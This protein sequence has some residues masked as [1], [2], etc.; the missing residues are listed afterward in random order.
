MGGLEERELTSEDSGSNS[1]RTPQ[2]E[3]VYWINERERVRRKKES[4]ASK[5]WSDDPVFQEVYFC[6][7]HREHDKVTKWIR[8]NWSH[9]AHPNFPLAICVARIFNYPPTLTSFGFPDVWDPEALRGVLLTREWKGMQTWSGAYLITT[10][11]RKMSKVEYCVEILNAAHAADL[12]VPLSMCETL[13]G[14]QRAIRQL[15]GFGSFLAAQV[16]AD[17]KNTEGYHLRDAED[18][19]EFS[20]P[21]P[22]SLRGLGWFYGRA[23]VPESQYDYLIRGVEEYVTPRLNPEVGRLCAQD[24]QNCLCEFDKYMRVKTGS[25]RSKRRYE[26]KGWA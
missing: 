23:T 24:L 13:E 9:P 7:V 26:G 21:G 20:A 11:G 17:L 8:T 2:D 19:W 4:G 25:G 3:L 6:N 1:T 5:P 12:S 15:E 18:W 14:A 22:G 10:H 16:V